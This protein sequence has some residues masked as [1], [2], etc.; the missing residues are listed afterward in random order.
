MEKY[1]I[2]KVCS[3][4]CGGKERYDSVWRGLLALPDR[5]K[6]YVFIHDGARPFVDE[7]ILRRG[8]ENVEEYGAC[9]AGM[10]SKD[11]VK[12]SDD[13]AFALE[14]PDRS[15]VWIVQTPQVFEKSLIT[16]AYERLMKAGSEERIHVTDDAMV[17]EQMMK[18][19]VKLFEGSYT[20]IKLTTPED[21]KIAE[22]I[23]G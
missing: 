14:T 12:L 13:K 5:G 22:V 19:P 10:P 21:M 3:I 17:V 6:G 23:A 7:N 9:V 2:T 18:V 15:R 1:G 16:E 4:V 20:N 11:T 8:Y